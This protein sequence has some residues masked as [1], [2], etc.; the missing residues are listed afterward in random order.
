MG[1]TQISTGGVKDDAV[2]AGK[3][4][5]DA[6]GQSEI[7]DEAVDEAR[8][9]VSN[10]G[11]NG[12]FLQKQSGNT[13]GLTWAAANEYTHPNHSGEVTSSADGAQT[14]ATN[15]VDEDKLKISNAGTNGQF[16]QKQSGNTGGLT[17]ADVTIPPA[18]NTVDLVA[19]GAIAAGKPVVIKSNGKA[20]QVKETTTNVTN[21]SNTGQTAIYNA[22]VMDQFGCAYNPDANSNGVTL[23][24]WENG[25]GYIKCTAARH[26]GDTSMTVLSFS[27]G[28]N[29]SSSN[30]AHSS[31]TTEVAYVG[32][33]YWLVVWSTG[34][35]NT[36]TPVKARTVRW[37]DSN[38]TFEMGTETNLTG[39]VSGRRFAIA[40]VSNTR[41]V[42]TFRQES[43][44]GGAGVDKA[45]TVVLDFTGSGTG[46]D[47]SSG[48]A[49]KPESSSMNAGDW[50]S[51]IYDSAN[52]RIV[53]A[54]VFAGANCIV[55]AGTISGSAGSG[56]I[57][58]GTPV[59]LQSG[60][61]FGAGL[62]YDSTNNKIVCKWSASNSGDADQKACVLT[63][64]S[65]D[66]SISAG[67]VATTTNQA[68]IA[69]SLG[70]LAA[71]DGIFMTCYHRGTANGSGKGTTLTVSGTTV[72]WNTSGEGTWGNHTSKF[73]RVIYDTNNDN[74]QV[75]SNANS[76]GYWG[77]H[78]Y[79]SNQKA[80]SVT[81]NINSGH[82]NFIGFAE[83]AI[84]DGNTGT[85]KTYG[86]V[87]GNQ[88]GL[89]AGSPYYVKND[90]T[91]DSGG[92]TAYAGGLALSSST[93]LIQRKMN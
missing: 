66:N 70:Q 38:N 30:N 9:Q 63:T 26:N 67:T 61:S 5:A 35:Q 84:S 69:N 27:G 65:S 87:V 60:S 44:S 90:G 74:W 11:S 43:S 24:A 75:F 53:H 29:V 52:S 19:D 28:T 78:I 48:S 31:A 73:M 15:V 82:T 2:T 4:P 3:I 86:N 10:A 89:S 21:P 54:G 14:I 50:P 85:I 16:L 18:G 92:G 64:S 23:F 7:A 51:M 93:L 34:G 76:G 68:T 72:T 17:W 56:T 47:I 46:R 55:T 71:G 13:G 25:D 37:V 1:L 58:W 32:D 59:T 22:A 77:P 91:L 39:N 45:T 57:T 6:V 81:T 88:S 8:L 20:E 79:G 41:C 36:S 83:D 62:A 33:N 40:R 80:T 42:V 49:T 12:Q